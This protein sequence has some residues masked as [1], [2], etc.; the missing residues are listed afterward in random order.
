MTKDLMIFTRLALSTGARLR[1]VLTIRKKDINFDTGVVDLVNHK[2]NRRYKGYLNK[3]LV[4]DLLE[5]CE[6]LGTEEYVVGRG[7]KELHISTINRRMKIIMD[8]VFNELVTD[9]RERVVV[10]TLRHTF[11]SLLAIQG[12]SIQQIMK[13][14]DHTTMKQSLVYAKL[15]PNSGFNQVELL[16]L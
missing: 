15:S 11:G 8:R 6:D 14:L 3:K 12:T 16:G 10:H 9:S 5:W 4:E 2:S 13:L 7:H 1:S